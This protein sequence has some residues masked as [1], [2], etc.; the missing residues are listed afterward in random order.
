MGS[1]F[2]RSDFKCASA[3]IKLSNLAFKRETKSET[4][5]DKLLL[6]GRSCKPASCD[7]HQYERPN[8]DWDDSIPASPGYKQLKSGEFTS[9][10]DSADNILSLELF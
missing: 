9:D 8:E 7:T 5:S 4:K 2:P 1:C 6:S 3:N 10:D